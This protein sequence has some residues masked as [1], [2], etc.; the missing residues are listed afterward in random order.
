MNSRT[1]RRHRPLPILHLALSAC[2]LIPV[3][4][5]IV[6]SSGVQAAEAA[7][8]RSDAAAIDAFLR[9]EAEKKGR[10]GL[11]VAVVKDGHLVLAKAYGKR[12]LETG[13]AADGNTLFAIGSVTKQ[14][15]CASV[16]MLADEGKLSPAD[17]VSKYYPG[18]TKADEITLLDLMHHTSGYPDYYPLD[19]VDRRMRRGIAPDEL[20][21]QYA[22]GKLDFAPG[23]KWSYSNTG[24]IILGRVVEKVSGLPLGRFMEQRLFKPLGM[25]RT[26]YEP[27]AGDERL[28]KGY[29]AF[30][31]GGPERIDPEGRGWLEGAGGVYSTPTDM[32]A[33]SMALMSG[34]VLQPGSLKL[35]TTQ[36]ELAD[37]KLTDYGCGL[38]VSLRNGRRV[39]AHNGAVSGFAAASSMVP[40]T[41][42]AVILMANKEN[43]LAGLPGKLLAILTQ[44]E[45]QIPKVA[46]PSADRLALE[47][48]EALQSGKVDRKKFSDD[49]NLFLTDEK[50]RR[51]AAR[52]APHGKALKTELLSRAERGGME[53]TRTSL[54][55]SSIKLVVLIYR[56]PDGTVEQ[57]FV[58][59]E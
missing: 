13:A 8:D 43:G 58:D 21:R 33:W 16:L 25:T 22:G 40:S 35:M 41:R 34:K 20:I 2:V 4:D 11:S 38:S 37:G 1:A 3:V 30:A 32:A 55:C 27:E 6:L 17:K 36:R 19:F 26:V 47:M 59:E 14:L 45:A 54:Q 31:T 52:L 39:W 56:R 9:A 51:A 42:S 12:S 10:V 5:F 53:V 57:C 28:A 23:T 44:D 18:L 46:G 49:F 24:Y 50:V 29:T 15:T 48:F 7:L